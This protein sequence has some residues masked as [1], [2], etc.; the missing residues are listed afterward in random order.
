[1]HAI[2][3]LVLLGAALPGRSWATVS[4]GTWLAHSPDDINTTNIPGLQT[5]S[6]DDATVNATL[7]FSVT[8]EGTSYS[9]VT[10]STN[11]WLEFGGNT[12]GTSD[13][14][15]ACLPT[16]KH[17]N[18]FLA[19]YWNDLD[20]FGTN[21]RYGTVGT[22]PNRT[23]L[24]DYE[25]DVDPTVDN[26]GADDIRFQ[27]QVHERSNIINVRYR[28]S[29]N[30]ANGQGTTIGFQGAGGASGTARP[31]TC[32]GKVLDDNRPDEGWSVDVGRA[33]LVPLFAIMAHS[34][35][36]ISGFTTLSGDNAIAG[37][38]LPF[39]V[40]IEGTSYSTVTIGTNGIIQFGTT[41]GA[42]PTANAALPSS[43]FPNPTL[44][45]YWDD[46]QTEGGNIRYGTVGSSPNRTFIVDFQENRV[47]ATGDKVNGQV[48]IHERSNLLNVKY[49][50][51]M[52]PGANGQTATIGFQGAG[53]SSAVAYP[54]TF[55]GKIL[56]DDRPDEGW[57]VHAL[58]L[59]AMVLHASTAYSPNDI[60]GFTMLSGDN[61]IAGVTLP[62]SVTI[63]GTSYT[64]L[65]I[66]TN[67]IIQFGTTTG[68]NPT[69]NAALPSSSFPNPTL[70]YYWDDLQTEGSNIEYA[71]VGTSPN[72]T[73]I[74]DFQENRVASSGDKVNGQVQ[75]HE[76]SNVLDVKYRSTISANANGQAATIG[77]QGA[78]GASA[79]AYPLT[80]NGKILDD[81]R[82]NSGWSVSPLPVCGNGAVE[83]KEQCDQGAANGT[84]GSCCTSSCTFKTAGTVCRAVADVCD[85]AETCSGSSATCPADGFASS[86]TV[87]RVAAGECDLPENCPGNGPSCPADAKES[88]GTA[89]TSDGNPCT[90][91][92]CDGTSNAC[93]H[94]A[95]NAG[96]LCRASAGACDP[97]ETCTGTSTTCPADAKTPAGTV[98]RPGAGP[99][100]IAES[101]DGVDNACPPDLFQPPTTE[102][103]PS[104][105]VCDPA[106]N[107]T[108]VSAACPPDAKSTAV[109]RPAAG[110][111]D[112]AESC[113]GVN[114]GCPADAFKPAT[115][116]CRPSAGVCDPAENCT[117]SSVACPPDG[118]QT[119]VCRPAAGACD[120]PESCDGVS[121]DCPPDLFE[122]TGFVCRV[123]VDACDRVEDCS[124]TSATCPP[125]AFLPAG[126]LC[127][128]EA[129]DCDEAEFCD[130]TSGACPPDAFAPS[131][132][133]CRASAGPCDV[134]ENCTGTTASCPPDA[135]ATAGSVCRPPAGDCDVQEVCTG[136]SVDCPADTLLPAGTICRAAGG[137]CDVTETCTGS[138]AACPADVKSNAECRP[139]VGVCDV[140]ESC[141]G[142]GNDCPPDGFLPSAV[143]CRASAGTCDPAENCTG[144]SASCPPD[145]KSTAECRPAAGPC[146]VAESCDGLTNDCPLDTFASSSTTCRPAAGPCDIPE[147]CTGLGP[148]CPP[149]AVHS[150]ADAFVCR[151]SAG[152][153]DPAETCDGTG[154]SCPPDARSTAVCRPAAGP[155]DLTDSCD[156]VN[157]DCPP[158]AKS[159][160]VCR[161][162]A[163][164]C[165]RADSC[166]GVND[167]CPPDAKSTAV[168]RP[169]ADSCDIA[170][171]CDGSSDTCPPDAVQ[172]DGASCS[173]DNTC[174]IGDTCQSGV[175][176]GTPDPDGCADDFLCY[177][178]R[179]GTPFTPILAVNLADQFE[180]NQNYDLVKV[181]DLCT[182]TNKN[183]QGV[184]DQQTHLRS[185]KIRAVAG[186]PRFSRRHVKVTNQLPAQQF[187]DVL[188]PDLLYVPTA[189]S[190]TTPP[191]EPGPNDV[192][193][194]KCYKAKVT[195]GTPKFPKG[196]QVTVTDQFRTTPGV[197]DVKKPR[198][199]CTP[200]SKNG[201][202]VHNPDAHLVCYVARPARGQAKHVPRAPVYV[203]DQFGPQTLA[204]VKEDELC[205]PS[206]KTVLP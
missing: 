105:G 109:C 201:E 14:T 141:D 130:G 51:T 118:K 194:Y 83:T 165:D 179:T 42:N 32:N 20:T 88:A 116:V 159:T 66:G 111:C 64:T 108:G 137:V 5:F 3:L 55:N 203:H 2:G 86:S 102:C 202:P 72:R 114:N 77:F 80:F 26:G 163:G 160:A 47:A 60:S 52:S 184:L 152:P 10:I 144:S 75:I 150:A 71:T 166:D 74:V 41:T 173:D 95:G 90:L 49:R 154:V 1:M 195:A 133:E 15:N 143:E 56:D 132:A 91:D 119:G 18:P 188:K 107:C 69:T 46:L 161:P 81:N 27:V 106:E 59:G 122:P 34:P 121:D 200:V 181:L 156:G 142:V 136:T 162:A 96:A 50:S 45:Y 153:C 61:A 124:G 53:G 44:F 57:S 54:L 148:D 189:K 48:Q 82:P 190:L 151:P 87:C 198:H 117:G 168:C 155:C 23:F 110:A 70:F 164:P 31:L 79:T 183:N 192:D 39:S 17:T 33:G 36:D 177:K 85:V 8:I 84:T 112:V 35:D 78:G 146:D 12:Q 29:G 123:S 204:T 175:C 97:D 38:T 62:F 13:P 58:P 63:D 126:T 206:L 182:P 24:V 169:A 113:D 176:T 16:S 170:E 94:P 139:A 147:S 115:A 37:V 125:D 9:S 186:S 185:Y 145:A 172:P 89:C 11:G 93:Q 19:A 138:N 171:S 129:G 103:R 22:S 180:A 92:Q 73:F 25:V 7:P 128:P 135:F 131:T 43:S 157:D 104:A 76:R 187:L 65:T 127:R 100:D 99:C 40:T 197:F 67:G 98:C 199:L 28:E 149:D 191:P 140:A 178:A 193:H 6:G 101:C 134:A 205:I 68:A 21:I 158:D 120:V 30:L 196:I 174:T 4:L 167:S